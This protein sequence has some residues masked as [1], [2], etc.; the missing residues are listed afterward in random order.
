MANE[1]LLPPVLP[2]AVVNPAD[3][4]PGA[5]NVTSAFVDG[6]LASGWG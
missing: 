4:L 3:S 1:Q 2:D 5:Y 6:A